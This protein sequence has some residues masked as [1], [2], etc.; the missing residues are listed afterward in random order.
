MSGINV[1]KK[2]LITVKFKNY[3]VKLL[4]AV[5]SLFSALSFSASASLN[6]T[7][8]KSQIYVN[9]NQVQA[10]AYNI[11]GN[12]YFKL[13]DI[14]YYLN[15]TECQF[16]ADWLPDE[17][18]IDITVGNKYVPVGSEG[19]LTNDTHSIAVGTSTATVTVNGSPVHL[20]AY[21]INGNNYF[22]LRDLSGVLG[23]GVSW[24]E[25]Q[26]GVLIYTNSDGQN[27]QIDTVYSE[28]INDVIRLV[29]EARANEGIAPLTADTSLT[30]AAAVRASELNTLFSH[31]RP[32]GSSC[33]TV[34]KEM[35]IKY[36]TCAENIAIGQR[37]PQ[38]VVNSWLN[39]SGHRANIMNPKLT[40]IG[41]GVTAAAYDGYSGYAWVQLFTN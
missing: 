2:G 20:S 37:T 38:D 6:I 32:N 22:K 9:G 25:A 7:A 40:K 14:A 13:R 30:S 12:N 36:S 1:I 33:F 15:G 29:N 28:Y 34:L 3:S 11:N 39:S 18:C 8:S 5:F 17:G 23:F 16:A 41:V 27:V 31:S 26:N 19:I 35:N 24:L 21:N 10:N 4:I